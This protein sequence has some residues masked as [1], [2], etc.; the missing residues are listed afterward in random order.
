LFQ[1]AVFVGWEDDE[2]LGVVEIVEEFLLV[3]HQVWCNSMT[4]ECRYEL[5]Q[6]V[7]SNLGQVDRDN[8]PVRF[9]VR[10]DE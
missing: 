5:L 2:I 4:D 1:D 8:V 7:T 3:G 10:P 6:E 9:P